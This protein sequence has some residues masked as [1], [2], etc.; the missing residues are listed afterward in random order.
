MYDYVS[1]LIGP[2]PIGIEFFYGIATII[3]FAILMALIIIPIFLI[4]GVLRN[5]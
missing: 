2:L 4:I 1:M 5:I 3:L